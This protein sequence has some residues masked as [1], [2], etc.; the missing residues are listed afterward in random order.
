MRL[1]NGP[2][3]VDPFGA[4]LD[5]SCP[6]GHSFGRC[7]GFEAVLASAAANRQLDDPFISVTDSG[8]LRVNQTRRFPVVAEVGVLSKAEIVDES[9]SAFADEGQEAGV[10][11]GTLRIARRE[12][13][14]HEDSPRVH[15]AHP[16]RDGPTGRQ[17]PHSIET[18]PEI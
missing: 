6:T 15:N 10:L 11:P 3:L 4:S 1:V 12:H 7:T 14:Q 8:G 17:A 2:M 13:S 16:I 18:I 5:L 9:Q